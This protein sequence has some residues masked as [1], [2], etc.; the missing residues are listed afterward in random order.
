MPLTL[1]VEVAFIS[2]P[3]V[4]VWSKFLMLGVTR[5]RTSDDNIKNVGET[6]VRLLWTEREMEQGHR[7]MKIFGGAMPRSENLEVGVR[8][9]DLF[10]GPQ[11]DGQNLHRWLE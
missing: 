10:I 4:A 9:G 1:F 3:N 7:N 8:E 5:R 6:S 11:Y 2:G